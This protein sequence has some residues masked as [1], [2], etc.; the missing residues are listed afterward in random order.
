MTE[1][2]IEE[3]FEIKE[4]PVQTLPEYR[5]PL[6]EK[7]IC[8]AMDENTEFEDFDRIVINFLDLVTPEMLSIHA[9]QGRHDS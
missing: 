4:Y 7:L 3:V 2:M 6:V 8:A 5:R 9:L 1:E